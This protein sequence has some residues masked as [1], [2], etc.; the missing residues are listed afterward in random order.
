[1]SWKNVSTSTLK[2]RLCKAGLYSRIAVKKPLLRKQNNVKRFQWANAHKDSIIEQRNK[3]IWNDESKFEILGQVEGS[4]YG[5]ELMKEL[6]NPVSHQ[7]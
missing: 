4:I 1:M 7:P 3:V 5:E 2:R 6:Q